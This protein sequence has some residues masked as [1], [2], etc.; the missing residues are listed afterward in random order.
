[1]L[2]WMFAYDHTKYARYLL[3][4]LCDMLALEQNHPSAYQAIEAGDFVVQGRLWN[5]FG[6]VAVEQ[7]IEQT[8]NCDTK[9][10]G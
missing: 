4:Y 3:V 10:K 2:P 5:G 6:Q 8:N 9:S 1:M 7:T